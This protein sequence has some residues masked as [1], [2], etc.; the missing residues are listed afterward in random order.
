MPLTN[1]EKQKRWRDKQKALNLDEYKKKHNEEQKISRMKQK[2][3]LNNLP[4][5]EKKKKKDAENKKRIRERV[6]KCREKKSKLSECTTPYST[7]SKLNRAVS[8]AR[9][10]LP[11]SPRRRKA[12]ISKLAVDESIVKPKQLFKNELDKNKDNS[13]PDV[14]DMV[15]KFYEQDDISR[16]APGKK[17]VMVIYANG[18]KITKQKRHL[19]TSLKEAHALFLKNHPSISLG[20]SKFAQLR[21]KHVLLNSKLPHNFCMCKYHE[22]FINSL[23]SLSRSIAHIPPYT[24]DFLNTLICDI[25]TENCWLKK[26]DECNFEKA[27]LDKFSLSEDDSVSWYVWKMDG[28]ER[29]DKVLQEGTTQELC[30]YIYS[31]LPTFMEYCYI[32]RNQAEKYNAAREKAL[33]EDFDRKQALIQ[34]DFSENYKCMF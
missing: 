20:K 13:K 17:D 3:N 15:E 31:Q 24:H 29:I 34:V 16:I 12:V 22:N 8:R 26:C 5:A 1:A 28:K 14:V 6:R 9:K 30:D 11:S 25:A 18:E 19:F 21:P 4:A 7:K 23:N 10:S 27:F 32:K 33:S 2:Y